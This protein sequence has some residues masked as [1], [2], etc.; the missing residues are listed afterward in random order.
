L[1]QRVLIPCPGTSNVRSTDH[2]QSHGLEAKDRAP[3]L[4]RE[5]VNK[6]SQTGPH[7]RARRVRAT[8]SHPAASFPSNAAQ[9]RREHRSH[10]G[11]VHAARAENGP[12]RG[13]WGR[14]GKE[15][16]VDTTA[17]AL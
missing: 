1:Q 2:Q 7:A 11:L 5:G 16:A 3:Q 13:T 6:T 9:T 4:A 10:S 12:Q 17:R 8:I 15:I 14:S